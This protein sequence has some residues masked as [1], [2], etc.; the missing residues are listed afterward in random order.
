MSEKI[1]SNPDN[2]RHSMKKAPI[3]I[4]LLF[5]CSVVY[6]QQSETDINA[7]QVPQ[8]LLSYPNPLFQSGDEELKEFPGEAIGDLEKEK[9]IRIS[10]VYRMHVLAIDS[11]VQDDL[12]QAEA[13]INDAFAAIQSLMD[14]F[15]EIQSNRRFSALYRSV[16]AEYREFYAIWGIFMP[17]RMNCLLKKMTGLLKVIHCLII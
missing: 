1:V 6:A 9:L 7:A 13:Y 12:V 10:D 15:P 8:K 14:D 16:M 2:H 3:L 4:I 5:C 11:Q 17:F